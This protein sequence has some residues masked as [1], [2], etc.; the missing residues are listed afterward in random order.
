MEQVHDLRQ[1]RAG[2]L[3]E[4]RQLSVIANRA[5]AARGQRFAARSAVD[6]IPAGATTRQNGAMI[7]LWLQPILCSPIFEWT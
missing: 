2:D 1:T 4:P 5:A 3:H 7:E 6:R